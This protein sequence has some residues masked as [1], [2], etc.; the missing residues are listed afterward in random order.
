MKKFL[1]KIALFIFVPALLYLG[2]FSLLK[3]QF[4]KKINKYSVII[5]GD[6]QTLFIKHPK[7]FNYSIYGSA[8]FVH[9]EFVKE[10]AKQLKGKRIYIACNY[11]NFSKLYQNRLEN[12]SLYPGWR[13]IM[14]KHLDQY[15]IF[16]QK[17]SEI[18]PKDLN[19]TFFD[20]KK[21]PDL[22][23]KIYIDDEKDNSTNSI[24][25]DTLSIKNTIQRHW[26]EPAYILPDS[27]QRD[28]LKKL[29]I[30]LK[31]MHC[32]VVLLKM[33]LTNYY[34]NN[35][36]LEIKLEFA[37]LPNKFNIRL[38]DLN[39][40]LPISNEYKYFKDYGHLNKI[41]DSLVFNY[42]ENN[43]INALTHSILQE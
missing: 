17:Y 2:L 29:I 42:I 10:F 9:F 23:R 5:L 34:L 7:I 3:I 36:P 8:Y 41:G 21:L 24:E 1:I 20:I 40:A 18:R 15:R 37:E 30:L 13:A 39:A 12:D 14:F 32:D 6:S 35:I 33:P 11:H 28:Y 43:E 27:I 19:Y 31:N 26:H 22:F 4:N 16:N 38:L 25:N